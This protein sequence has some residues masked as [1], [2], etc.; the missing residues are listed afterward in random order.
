MDVLKLHPRIKPNVPPCRRQPCPRGSP[1]WGQA[2][3]HRRLAGAEQ[4]SLSAGWLPRER[5][6]KGQTACDWVLLPKAL[7]RSCEAFSIEGTRAPGVLPSWSSLRGKEIACLPRGS[8][9]FLS[10][11]IFSVAS[12]RKLWPDLETKGREQVTPEF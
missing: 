4:S 7:V 8:K 6:R 9:V 11:G 1:G 5:E 3:Q 10:Y 12:S 2:L